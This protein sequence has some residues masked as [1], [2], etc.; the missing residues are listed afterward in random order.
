[1]QKFLQI[2][3]QHVQWLALAI[4]A[5][6]LGFMG[7]SYVYKPNINVTLGGKVVEP[8]K[9]DQ[10]IVDGPITDLTHAMEENTA[11]VNITPKDVVTIFLHH[12][13]D[14]SANLD[15]LA[16]V[17][18]ADL[19]GGGLVPNG[20]AG[21]GDQTNQKLAKLPTLPAATFVAIAPYR[22]MI[23]FADPNFDVANAAAG[24]VVPILQKDIDA[25]SVEYKVD[26]KALAK[27]FTDVFPPAIAPPQ[28]FSTM[29]LRVSLY[30]QELDAAGKWGN[31]TEIPALFI[32]KL[33][34]LPGPGN[35]PP[36]QPAFMYE[37]WA[38][39]N[40]ELIIH[41]PFYQTAKNA[42]T[43]VAPDQVAPP[44]AAAAGAAANVPVANAK[45][46]VQPA[47]GPA[48][49]P[50]AKGAG[51]VAPVLAP[52]PPAFMPSM[53]PPA[54]GG[55]QGQVFNPLLKVAD[56]VIIA[57]DDTV[58]PEKTYRYYLQYRL[59]NTL[60]LANRLG[61]D[62][63]VTQFALISPGPDVSTPTDKVTIPSRTHI[64][65]KNTQGGMAHFEVFQWTPNPHQTEVSAT[66]GDAL[67]P[68]PW[69]LVDVRQ[70]PSG[71][72]VLLADANGNEMRR[73]LLKDNA[74]PKRLEDEKAA[75]AALAPAVGP[76]APP[77][78]TAPP[79]PGRPGVAPPNN[80]ND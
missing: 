72:Y 1:M 53:M 23:E 35:T 34:D 76:L 41:P 70:D 64:F 31:Q 16:G 71:K 38:G 40:Q 20:P 61:A 59:L 74:D 62:A 25:V 60:F 51:G 45:P 17:F 6:Y 49:A 50:L 13:A 3:E 63:I 11:D 66:A 44:A 55:W 75:A 2:A 15:L 68:S 58:V 57:H 47:P 69:I 7:W 65:V 14:A 32:N 28:V 39:A 5:A 12:I 22:T 73:D 79:V 24:A 80:N 36:Q 10:F 77:P 30:R 29:Y 18:P 21:P 4:G 56:D 37:S 52:P 43:W 19:N 26:M 8:G 33:P 27:A 48:G 67:V 42:T 78:G 9:V 54:A 46:G